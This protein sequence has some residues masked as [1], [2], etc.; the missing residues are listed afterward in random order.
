MSTNY[1]EA[2]VRVSEWIAVR[3]QQIDGGGIDPQVIHSLAI[4]DPQGERRT[5]LAELRMDD[6]RTVL[7]QSRQ[8][9]GQAAP[10]AEALQAAA[11]RVAETPG[12][13]GGI[14]PDPRADALAALLDKLA[15]WLTSER[16]V[17][18]LVEC[19]W[20]AQAQALAYALGVEVVSGEAD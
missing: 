15:C 2:A 12:L 9:Y 18:D 1:L 17:V 4:P 6:L 5:V 11:R 8:Q 19:C 16:S 10:L 20:M 13:Y 3:Q 14:V 7:H